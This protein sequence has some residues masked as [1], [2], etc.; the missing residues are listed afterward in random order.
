M[1]TNFS[2]QMINRNKLYSGLFSIVLIYVVMTIFELIFFIFVVCPVITDNIRSLMKSYTYENETVLNF[3]PSPLVV[4]KVLNNREYRLINNFNFANYLIIIILIL[5]LTSLLFYLYLKVGIIEQIEH[6]EASDNMDIIINTRNVTP[7][8]SS[9]IRTE[10]E[11]SYQES[12]YPDTLV[13][14]NSTLFYNQRS[15][16]ANSNVTR[17]SSIKF[18]YLNHAV[19]CAVSTVSCLI[20]FQVF[21][22]NYGLEFKY[23]GTENEL[24]VLFIESI[25]KS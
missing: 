18:I 17:R 5:L 4:T 15:I 7:R 16:S 3:E 11:S 14:T 10:T 23:V 21:F 25:N 20:F 6:T 8:S 19:R 24:I 2:N 13:S 1:F 9:A 22:Y 12:T